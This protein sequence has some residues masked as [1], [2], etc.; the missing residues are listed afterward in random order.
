MGKVISKE[1]VTREQIQEMCR[2]VGREISRDYQGKDLILIAVLKGAVVFLSDLMREIDVPLT[3]DFMSVSSYSG[4]KSSGVVK[5]IKDIDQDIAGKD[6][7]IVEDVVDTGLTLRHLKKLLATRGPASIRLCTAFDKPDCRV[8]D[9]DVDYIGMA[10][11]NE[12]VVGYGLDY[13]QLY[14]QL[15]YV[16]VLADDGKD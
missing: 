2:R 13:K 14:R 4:T 6:V 15:P 5:I 9:V 1:L 11:P 3:I 8:V 7:L 16:A 10:I 12:F